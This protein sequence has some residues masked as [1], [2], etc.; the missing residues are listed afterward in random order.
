MGIYRHRQ[1]TVGA[2]P[3]RKRRRTE[4]ADERLLTV[5]CLALGNRR[6][7]EIA[8]EQII[9]ALN[10]LWSLEREN[11]RM[12]AE[13][14]ELRAEITCLKAGASTRSASA[15]AGNGPSLRWSLPKT[16]TRN[17]NSTRSG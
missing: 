15:F 9:G 3:A 7:L 6:Q 17:E 8:N 2:A 16:S 4:I 14:Q 10:R 5:E 1:P 12:A 13:L 11:W